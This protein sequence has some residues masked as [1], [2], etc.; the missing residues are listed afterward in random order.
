MKL[1]IERIKGF[2]KYKDLM[3]QLVS[4]DLKLKYRR[5]FLGYVWSVLNPLFIMVVQS[6]I[7]THFFNRGIA[8]YP[9]FLISGQLLFNFTNISTNQAMHSITGNASL[10]KKTYLPKYVF[11]V[12][13][14]A[15]CMID[16][17]LSVGALLIVM[18]FTGAT[19]SYHL[20]FF[21]LILVQCFVFNVGLGMFLGAMNVYFRDIQYIYKAFTTAWMYATPLFYPVSALP[22]NLEF[23]IVHFNPMYSYVQQMRCLTLYNCFPDPLMVGMGCGFSLIML[24]IGTIVFTKTQKNFILYI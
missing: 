15:S 5:S 12:S 9:V 19:F 13:K 23:I 2:I 14:V 3:I 17:F 18:L 21:P 1:F 11:A 6:I 24:I 7:F 16:C 20:I 8:N 4:R 10:L 22:Y